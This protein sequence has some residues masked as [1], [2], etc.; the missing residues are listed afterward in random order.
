MQ[1]SNTAAEQYAAQIHRANA[2]QARLQSTTFETSAAWDRMA[3][4]FR[5]DPRRPFDSNLAALAA[6]I[7]PSDT[8]VDVGGGAGRVGLALA[9]ACAEVVNIEPSVGMGQQFTESAGEAGVTNA[10]LVTADWLDEHAVP[11]M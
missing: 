11:G 3:P 7:K 9:R 1:S 2:Q 10:R 6:H 4:I 8:V 5:A